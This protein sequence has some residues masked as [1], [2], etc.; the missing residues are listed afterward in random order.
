MNVEQRAER[1]TAAGTADDGLRPFPPYAWAVA[2]M[3]TADDGLRTFPPYA[4]P[5]PTRRAEKRS[6]IRRTAPAEA[7][8]PQRRPTLRPAREL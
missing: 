1:M 6:V 8:T 3:E 5:S 2:G 7:R 4:C